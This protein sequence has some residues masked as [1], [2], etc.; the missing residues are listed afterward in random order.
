MSRICVATAD[1]R[2]YYAL[3]SRLRK[4][5]IPF[6]SLSPGDSVG[7]C[8]LVLTTSAEA[9]QYGAVAVALENL[10]ESG[11]VF[12]AQILSRLSKEGRTLLVGIDPGSRIGMA[13][14]LGETRLASQTFN[15]RSGAC[16]G[17]VRLVEGVSAERPV[18]R[19]GD[20]DPALAA[21]LA[22]N[23]AGRLQNAVVEIVDESG[24]SK[25]PNISGLRKDQGSAAR[26][27]FRR[28]EQ[29]SGGAK[30]VRRHR[31]ENESRQGRSRP[32]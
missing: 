15:S 20:G 30:V 21:W 23:L 6:L 12:R 25:N 9:G 27:A 18:I 13:A 5:G 4:A 17:V 22:D 19:I 26:I 11:D 28:G 24:T 2:A 14:F 31:R 29:F 8:D 32:P 1:S 10:D 3:V 7:E 16:N